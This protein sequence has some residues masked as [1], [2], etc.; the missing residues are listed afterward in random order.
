VDSGFDACGIN[1]TMLNLRGDIHQPLPKLGIRLGQ[2]LQLLFVIALLLL[3]FRDAFGE[4]LRGTRLKHGGIGHSLRY[5]LAQFTQP[6][7]R[8]DHKPCGGN[9]GHS[10]KSEYYILHTEPNR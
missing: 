3:N 1:L 9:A 10:G 2:C 5:R 4:P 7:H 6:K 8:H